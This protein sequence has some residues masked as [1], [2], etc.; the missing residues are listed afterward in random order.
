VVT[1]VEPEEMEANPH[2]P[3]APV[4]LRDPQAQY[5]FAN[6]NS[7]PSEFLSA[8]RMAGR[9]VA[10]LYA[11]DPEL[12]D[13]DSKVQSG[14]S[15]AISRLSLIE[16]RKAEFPKWVGYERETYWIS[17]IVWN[18]FQTD[19]RDKMREIDRFVS[20]RVSA[21][22][23]S[24]VVEFAPLAPSVDAVSDALANRTNLDLNLTTREEILATA[25]DIDLEAAKVIAEQFKKTNEKDRGMQ[26]L[27]PS[28]EG[29]QRI[30]Q[31]GNRP[32]NLDKERG[33]SDHGP[34]ETMAGGHNSIGRGEE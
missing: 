1:G 31:M 34:G 15:R 18:T 5:R 22:K 27:K 2:S 32:A 11:V 6:P 30:G 29:I 17:A 24:V 13:P 23:E 25:K 26:L 19:A 4:I 7:R 14:V 33:R 28:E 12:V 21:P 8:T 3:G 20:A 9:F 10:R 16:R